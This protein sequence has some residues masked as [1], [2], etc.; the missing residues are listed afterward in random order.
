MMSSIFSLFYFQTI[1]KLDMEVL[2]F[3]LFTEL[4]IL[5]WFSTWVLK[6][7]RNP[8]RKYFQTPITF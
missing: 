8:V 4:S 3:W 1:E 5:E 2:N 6:N 7:A